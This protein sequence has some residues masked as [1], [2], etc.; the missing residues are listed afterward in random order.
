MDSTKSCVVSNKKVWKHPKIMWINEEKCAA[1]G[2]MGENADRILP[3]RIKTVK[4]VANRKIARHVTKI[5]TLLWRM[6]QI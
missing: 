3:N 2:E 5:R 1:Y 4:A 6:R